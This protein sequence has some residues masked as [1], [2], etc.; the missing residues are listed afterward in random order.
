MKIKTYLAILSL[1]LP[2]A[3][4]AEDRAY[5]CTAEEATGYDYIDGRWLRERFRPDSKYQIKYSDSSWSV[6]EY[7]TEIDTDLCELTSKQVLRCDMNGE[8]VMNFST[9]KFSVT[10]T[11]P[12]VHSTRRNRDSV[13]LILGACLPM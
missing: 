2:C 13:T 11:A 3:L 1:L 8:F 12:Y 10:N 4:L 6:Y 7:Q 5:L 9:L